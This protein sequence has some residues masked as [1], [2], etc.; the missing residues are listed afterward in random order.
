M[1]NGTLKIAPQGFQQV[2]NIMGAKLVSNYLSCGH[3][4]FKNKDEIS[5]SKFEREK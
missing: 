3:I 4:L 5:N 1:A 2:A